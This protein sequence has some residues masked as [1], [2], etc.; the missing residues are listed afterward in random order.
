MARKNF[1]FKKINLDLDTL[2]GA[3]TDTISTVA[4][5]V[6][7]LADA[8]ADTAKVGQQIAKLYVEKK[9]EETALEDAYKE[10][11]KL[12]YELHKADA[13]G[14]LA[15]L[16]AE[17]EN[18]LVNIED[19]NNEIEALKASA[20]VVLDEDELVVNMAEGEEAEGEEPA[21]EED[22]LERMADAVEDAL[23]GLEDA[24]EA[25]LEK[26]ELCDEAPAVEEDEIEVTVEEYLDDEDFAAP[27][28]D[29][30][31]VVEVVELEEPAAEE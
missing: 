19:I 13:E 3:L 17:V 24:I 14:V 28:Q 6:L 5:K 7:D 21:E 23:D 12:Y 22:F 10:L 11:G 9:K 4:D 29:E 30:E 26:L 2:R 8:A 1:D 31:I 25:A 16:C 20:D 18:T 27:T 15:D